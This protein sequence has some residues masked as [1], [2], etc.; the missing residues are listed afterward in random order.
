VPTKTNTSLTEWLAINV[1]SGSTTPNMAT[2][3][4]IPRWNRPA[5]ECGHG[6]ISRL[7]SRP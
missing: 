2:Q 7:I 4:A 5:S 3:Q 6:S 1:A